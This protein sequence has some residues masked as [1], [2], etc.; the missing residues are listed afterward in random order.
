L[1]V[2]Q[3]SNKRVDSDHLEIIGEFQYIV[4]DLSLHRL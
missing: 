3:T 2:I 4:Q 1:T